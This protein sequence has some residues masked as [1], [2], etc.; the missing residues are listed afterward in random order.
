MIIFD[1]V[2][3][4]ER[5]E[6]YIKRISSYYEER[7]KQGLDP[8]SFSQTRLLNIDDDP[9]V[10]EVKKYIESKIKIELNH[11]W[12]QLQ[13]WPISSFSVKHIH[14]DP[15]AGNANYTSMLYLNDDFEGGV[16]YTDD[17]NILP[18]V[19]RLTLFNGREVY[20]GVTHVHK[21]NRYSII[22]WWNVDGK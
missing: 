7:C 21:R 2:I 9:I 22:F 8:M 6:Q 3:S 11:S 1:N 4:K 12:T 5:C 10:I 14:D 17:I 19:G 20:H 18:K 13:V 15:R 16:F